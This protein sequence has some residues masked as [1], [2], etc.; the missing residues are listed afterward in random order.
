MMQN[1]DANPGSALAAAIRSSGGAPQTADPPVLGALP[2]T[3]G[4]NA[5]SDEVELSLGIDQ[6]SQTLVLGFG[7]VVAW[8]A[9]TAVEARALAGALTEHAD[10]IDP[11]T[12]DGE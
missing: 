1:N 7:T 3:P 11:P 2:P 6:K 5:P 4:V 10:R 12:G 9:L 8:I